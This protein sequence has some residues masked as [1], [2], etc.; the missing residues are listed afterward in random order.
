MPF[1]GNISPKHFA[2]RW[3]VGSFWTVPFISSLASCFG[4]V[5]GT[6][7]AAYPREQE[8]CMAVAVLFGSVIL[9]A[10]GFIVGVLTAPYYMS[11]EDKAIEESEKMATAIRVALTELDRTCNS[12]TRGK[13][14]KEEI[15]ESRFNLLEDVHD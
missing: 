9:L 12:I 8:S 5:W 11:R 4:L 6:Y 7:I 14:K 1:M 3:I 10:L 15:L 2:R 13:G